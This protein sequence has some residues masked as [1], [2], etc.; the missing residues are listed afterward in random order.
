MSYILWLQNQHVR[1]HVVIL[2]HGIAYFNLE[3]RVINIINK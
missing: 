3:E 1:M 2:R